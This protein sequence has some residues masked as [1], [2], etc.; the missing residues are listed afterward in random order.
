MLLYE[1][2]ELSSLYYTFPI[3]RMSIDVKMAQG[4]DRCKFSNR[5]ELE[6]PTKIFSMPK[7]FSHSKTI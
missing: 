6:A 4:P 7:L 3:N 1:A 2:V 5:G